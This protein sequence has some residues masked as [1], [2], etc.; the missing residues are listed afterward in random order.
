MSGEGRV[1]GQENSV[2]VRKD[3]CC[4]PDGGIDR[5]TYRP[6]MTTVTR[7]QPS[8]RREILAD[9]FDRLKRVQ[10]A[11]GTVGALA[12]GRDATADT[13]RDALHALERDLL[14]AARQAERARLQIKP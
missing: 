13:L 7:P 1:G 14:L 11:G 12:E 5:G 2:V 10:A 9:L 6:G 8:S 4:F 3:A